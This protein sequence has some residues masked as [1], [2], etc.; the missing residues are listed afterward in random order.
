MGT[1]GYACHGRNLA[2]ALIQEGVDLGVE[3]LDYDPAHAAVL[4]Q[5]VKDAMAKDHHFETTVGNILPPYF[6]IK[7]SDKL[8]AFYG[9][10]VFEGTKMQPDWVRAINSEGV[11]GVIVPSKHVEDACKNSGV[12]KPISIVPHGYDPKIFHQD[13]KPNPELRPDTFKFLYVGGWKDGVRDRKGLDLVLRAYSQEFKKEEKVTFYAKI[14]SAYQDPQ[15]V[16]NNVKQLDLPKATERPEIVLL[17]N[18]VTDDVLAQ[19]YKCADV[20]VAPSKAEAFNM[21]VLEAMACGVPAITTNYGG[22]LDYVNNENGYL[23]DVE[24]MAPATGE[25]HIYEAAEWAVPSVA[26]L[27][28]LMRHC[29]ENREE[30]KAKGA[31]AVEDVKGFTWSDSA[32]KLIQAVDHA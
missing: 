16:M 26:H 2:Q 32:K 21:P 15:T 10:V 3:P 9:Y 28:K 30:L 8:P 5:P 17:F 20:L 14:N 12:T 25:R 22:Q 19:T 6:P 13:V 7:T 11:T 18:T 31:K 24:G 29:F 1:S 4:P 27:R 23:L